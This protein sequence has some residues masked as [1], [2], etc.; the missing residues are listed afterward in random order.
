MTDML[1]CYA[2]RDGKISQ[3]GLLIHV[4]M[5]DEEMKK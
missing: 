2:A 3:S 4:E 5:K 1:G